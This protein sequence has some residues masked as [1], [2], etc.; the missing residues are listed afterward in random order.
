ME[1]ETGQEPDHETVGKGGAKSQEDGLE[2]SPPDGDDERN[3]HRLGMAR[4]QA[5]QSAQKEGG[6][7]VNPGV[8]GSLLNQ[9]IEIVHER[10]MP[11]Y[12]LFP[13]GNCSRFKTVLI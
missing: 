7:K 12:P 8:K 1:G 3:H 11:P 5:M 2:N 10:N 6:G 9:L 4:L 13:R